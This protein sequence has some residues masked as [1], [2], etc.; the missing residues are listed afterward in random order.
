[1]TESL[2]IQ[3]IKEALTGMGWTQ[4]ELASAVEVSAQTVTNWLQ[5]KDFPRPAALLKLSR[6]LGLSFGELV[7]TAASE[8]VIAFRR[9]AATK[10]TLAH[11]EKAKH[12]GYLLKPLV[13]HL[14]KLDDDQTVF[15]QVGIDYDL[16][17]R[18]A[19]SRREAMKISQTDVLDYS[20]LISAFADNGAVLVPVLWGTKGRHENALHILLPDEAVTFV[21]LNLDAR[22]DDFKFWMAHELAHIFTP[23][24][25]GKDE[26]EDFADAFAAALLFPRELAAQVSATCDGHASQACV[27]RITAAAAKHEVSAV[28]V[29]KQVNAYRTVQGL[30]TLPIDEKVLHRIRNSGRIESVRDRVFRKADPTPSEFVKATQDVFGSQFF[31]ALK[32][33]LADGEGGVGYVQQ[34]VD[35][36][37]AD[38]S[39]LYEH[40]TH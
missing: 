8:P 38:A 37:R 2:R 15:R 28:T 36:S 23:S 17:E 11:V 3:P 39:A 1:M 14:S 10:T 27:T 33:M 31:D 19:K 4:R 20:K 18:L 30:P 16:V 13:R 6:A 12:M 40:L 29:F 22:I 34:V 7:E 32:R 35:A 26:G 25:C 21:Y 5:G 9:K 24:L